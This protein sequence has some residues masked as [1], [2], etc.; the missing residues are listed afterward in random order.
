MVSI[1]VPVYN[2]LLYLERC[3]DSLCKQTYKDL[4]ILLVDDG[5]KD[6][7]DK[8]C[9]E[10]SER[11]ERIRVFHKENGGT[12][13]ARNLGLTNA[14]GEYLAFVDSDDYIAEDMIEALV[15]A[16]ERKKVDIVQIGRDE[17]DEKGNP[18]AQICEIP[19]EENWI[20]SEDFLRELLMHRGDCSFCTKLVKRELFDDKRFPEGELNEDF[21]VLVKMLPEIEGILSLPKCGYHVFY[22]MGSNTRKKNSFSRVFLDNV[23]NADMVLNLVTEHYPQLLTEAKRFG[24]IQRMDY[25]MHIPISQMQRENKDYMEICSSLK[26]QKKEIKENPYLTKKNKSYLTLLRI[27]PKKIRQLHYFTMLLRGKV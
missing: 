4:E 5:S 19:T 6:G 23:K 11:D 26:I 1:I 3:V 14:K 17:I 24:L 20:L 12:S 13:S 9:E 7:T 18:L 21:H 22:A 8:L 10:M 27:A 2:N 16:M 15:E 25:L